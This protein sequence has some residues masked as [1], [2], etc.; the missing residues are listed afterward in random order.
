MSIHKQGAKTTIY[1]SSRNCPFSKSHFSET[2]YEYY[3][4]VANLQPKKSAAKFLKI[5]LKVKILGHKIILNRAFCIVKMSARKVTI[6]PGQ[7][8]KLIVFH[9]ECTKRK[10]CIS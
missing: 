8:S 4:H 1:T 5:G 2:H 3:D 9:L 6:F 10:N 7:K